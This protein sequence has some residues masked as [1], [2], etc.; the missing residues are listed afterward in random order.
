MVSKR[1]APILSADKEL[2]SRYFHCKTSPY[3]PDN[4][5]DGYINFGTAENY[6]L[7]DLLEPKAAEVNGLTELDSH[8]ADLHGKDSFRSAVSHCSANE[9]GG[10]FLP[11][12]LSRLALPRLFWKFWPIVCAI[13]ATPFWFQ[14]H[15]IRGLVMRLLCGRKLM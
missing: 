10:I 6:L 8:Y 3:H 4:A 9:L 14:H 13:R 11:T 12:I 15:F 1:V 7:W 5:P 2:V